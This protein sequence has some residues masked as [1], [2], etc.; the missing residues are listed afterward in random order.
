MRKNGTGRTRANRRGDREN[1]SKT[2]RTGAD[3][4][5]I[6][7]LWTTLSGFRIPASQPLRS[8]RSLRLRKHGAQFVGDVVQYKDAYRLCYI[9]GPEGLLIGLAQELS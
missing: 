4:S 9:R 7:G 1:L 8:L 2:E 3:G 6:I 5:P